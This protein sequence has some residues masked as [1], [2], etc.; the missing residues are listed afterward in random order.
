MKNVK[1][2]IGYILLVVAY[3]LLFVPIISVFFNINQGP[4]IKH[5]ID[6]QNF[7]ILS[8]LS[9]VI[10]IF[11]T[12]G[13]KFISRNIFSLRLFKKYLIFVFDII[14]VSTI[15]FVLLLN[16]SFLEKTYFL[17]IFLFFGFFLYILVHYDQSQ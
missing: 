5:S 2:A 4:G 9:L 16:N 14:I 13:W 8:W 12:I 15:I 6:A 3:C 7:K 10:I 1:R 11:L 17:V